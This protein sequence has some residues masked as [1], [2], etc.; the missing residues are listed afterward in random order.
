MNI[1]FGQC[2]HFDQVGL[3]KSRGKQWNF[4]ATW[5]TMPKKI[6]P[7]I[8]A[9]NDTFHDLAVRKNHKLIIVHLQTYPFA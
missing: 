8:M 1:S 2:E 6:Q 7:I 3:L 9:T 5:C 4:Y